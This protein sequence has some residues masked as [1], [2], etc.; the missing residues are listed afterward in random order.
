MEFLPML[1]EVISFTYQKFLLGD[2]VPVSNHQ[3]E[4]VI[5]YFLFNTFCTCWLF[6]CVII[7][8]K[9]PRRNWHMVFFVGSPENPYSKYYRNRVTMK[10]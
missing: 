5:C 8:V 1:R 6:C 3:G 7:V 2:R 10:T 4:V 9:F